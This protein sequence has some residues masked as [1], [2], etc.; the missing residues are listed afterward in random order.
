MLA[1][2]AVACEVIVWWALGDDASRR[3]F[4]L[5]STLA[6]PVLSGGFDAVAMAAVAVSTG[7]LT[8]GDDRGWWVAVFGAT[9]K[10]FPGIAWG[11]MP[12]WGRTGVAALAVTLAVLLAPMALGEGRDVYV[13][14]HAERGV[15]QESIAASATHLRDR[16]RVGDETEVAYRF[17][18]QEIVGAERWGT[19]SLVVFGAIVAAIAVRVRSGPVAT[20]PWVVAWPS[21]WWCCAGPRS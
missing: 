6:F 17:R 20:D 9:V 21:C 16:V 7:L 18:A 13:N 11:W 19:I 14:Y 15:Q 12:R 4:L 5:L 8:K 2:Q 3:R 10:V 1:L